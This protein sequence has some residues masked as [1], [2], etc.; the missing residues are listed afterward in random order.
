MAKWRIKL[1]AAKSLTIIFG[2]NTSNYT[3]KKLKIDGQEID[4]SSKAKYL[5]VTLQNN[6]FMNSHA[7]LTI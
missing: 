3:K 5:G 1:N 2:T 4:W 6:L 7:I